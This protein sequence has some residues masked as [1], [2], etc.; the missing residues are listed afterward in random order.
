M[1]LYNT[2]TYPTWYSN[3][4]FNTI[5]WYIRYF[6][7]SYAKWKLDLIFCFT[8]LFIKA[9]PSLYC[10]DVGDVTL[11]QTFQTIWD[12]QTIPHRIL[13]F[14]NIHWYSDIPPAHSTCTINFWL[15][16]HFGAASLLRFSANAYSVARN[17]L[18]SLHKSRVLDWY[19]NYDKNCQKF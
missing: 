19:Q 17:L 18:D 12:I 8:H 10:G 11:N 15:K 4:I 1:W 5:N 16:F 3:S 14:S 7:Y 6:S 9:P 13:I 2:N